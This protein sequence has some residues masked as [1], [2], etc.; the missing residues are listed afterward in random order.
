MSVSVLLNKPVE[1]DGEIGLTKIEAR[2]FIV[3]NLELD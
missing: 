3:G 2:K 1:T